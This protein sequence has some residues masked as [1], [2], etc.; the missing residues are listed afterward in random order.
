M[1]DA[2]D[3]LTDVVTKLRAPDGCP[4]DQK[5]THES[6]KPYFIEETYEVL[7]TI[8]QK[9]PTK[10]R[11]E[12]G[13]VLLQVMLHAQIESEAQRFT[14][15]DVIHD[16]T[17]KLIRRHPHV[18]EKDQGKSGS[19]N[20]DQVVSRWEILKRAER[21]DDDQPSSILESIPLALP[22]LQR[23]YQMQKRAARVGF[24]WTNP[25]QV[26]D[27]LDEELNELREATLQS[28]TQSS[29]ETPS[30]D[31]SQTGPSPEV[32]HEFGDV[33]F[34]MANMARFLK[35]NPEEVLRQATNR[36]GTRFKYMET[37]AAA[38]GQ[39]LP[40]LTAKEW[41]HWWEEAKQH[42]QSS[43]QDNSLTS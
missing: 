11:E 31:N 7:E 23:A 28:R 33:L 37:Q 39:E 30:T 1:S 9:N 8:D 12:L 13:D 27:K 3:K 35:I 5:Q 10:L 21:R 16:L 43:T 2:F 15:Q 19:L 32:E 17:M 26:I 42:E 29:K 4:W 14:I 38:V 6:L 18:F 25:Q 36:F 24:D 40:A 34:T 22:A 41:D 20:A